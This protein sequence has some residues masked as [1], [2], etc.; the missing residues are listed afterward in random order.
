MPFFF[1]ICTVCNF[2]FIIDFRFLLKL[3]KLTSQK[4]F[5]SLICL[6][7]FN[8]IIDCCTYIRM[9]VQ[10][11]KCKNEQKYMHLIL[12]IVSCERS[13][14]KCIWPF[15]A[16]LHASVRQIYAFDAFFKCACERST[17]K[18][19]WLFSLYLHASVRQMCT[20][21]DSF[22]VFEC[23]RSSNICIWH[24]SAYVDVSV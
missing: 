8:D 18:C 9:L 14:S 4:L 13:T 12:F 20:V 15:S 17:S 24:V 22:F 7:K 10:G 19:I 5:F 1:I 11:L 2:Y 21:C 3:L 23:E 6:I 16:Y